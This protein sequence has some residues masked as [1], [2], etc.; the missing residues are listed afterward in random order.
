VVAAD[1]RR[2]LARHR[3][4]FRVGRLSV[5]EKC[6]GHAERP[7][8]AFVGL[9]QRREYERCG[10]RSPRLRVCSRCPHSA[11]EET[12]LEG[13]RPYLIEETTPAVH[14]RCQ[15]EGINGPAM[16]RDVP[17]SVTRR[18]VRTGGKSPGRTHESGPHRR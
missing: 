17:R 12:R 15:A 18:R 10:T 4:R 5:H 13:P 16:P 2:R 9:H 11:F 1:V 8:C 3:R 14:W 6:F 7:G